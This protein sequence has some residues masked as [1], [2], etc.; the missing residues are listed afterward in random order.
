M[1]YPYV[2]YMYSYPH[3][4]AYQTFSETDLKRYIHRLS[5]RE[6]SL[7]IHIPFCQYKC[8][9]CN[10]FSLAG[11]NERQMEA[12]VEAMERHAGQLSEILP[13]DAAF[14]DLTLGGGT[15]LILPER[16]L[17][18]VFSAAERCF[19]IT[20]GK[21][22]IAVETSP[23]QTTEE[24]L[25]ILKEKGVSRISIGVQS[26]QERELLSL[27]RFHK[28][29]AAKKA[30]DLICR[31]K[32]ECVNMDFIYGIP[33]QTLESLEDS[34]Q[35]GLEFEP[36]EL[37]VY[38]LYVK[39]GTYLFQTGA[40]CGKS[41]FEMYRFVCGFLEAKGYRAYSMRRFVKQNKEG[42]DAGLP[43]SLC[44]FGN[45]L[46]VGCGGRSYIG[47]LHFC[48]PYAVEQRQCHAILQDYI[49]QEEYLQVT[50]GFWLS[51]EE[52]KRRYV[53]RH[54]L[55]GRGV[56]RKDYRAHFGSEAE[57]DFP[58]LSDW[59]GAGYA[60]KG[61]EFF[62][63]TRQGLAL[64]DFLGPQLISDEVRARMELSCGKN[65]AACPESGK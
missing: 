14:S 42:E 59:A 62:S 56:C 5:G 12:Y 46:S 58:L 60:V 32:F 13:H 35:Q 30:L 45:T 50:H 43:E 65:G 63:L 41:A 8:G 16:L 11:K 27:H 28:A 38:P 24:K 18:R 19:G 29:E 53:I 26:F 49:K 20:A 25:C 22:P 40:E 15:P 51:K 33:G 23:N 48:A 55:F 1:K 37:F 47:N 64:S 9:Y 17:R 39:P 36:D 57:D 4:K 54:I 34:L 7:Y 61:E 21:Q 10:L 52:E 2:Q 6:N 31:M 3:K 44:G